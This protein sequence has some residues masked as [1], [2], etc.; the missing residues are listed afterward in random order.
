MT[1]QRISKPPHHLVGAFGG[2]PNGPDRPD[3]AHTSLRSGF[4]TA[5]SKS[6]V[7]RKRRRQ[8]PA[9]PVRLGRLSRPRSMSDLVLVKS[10]GPAIRLS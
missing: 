1:L 5:I 4:S 3:G 10:G 7:E 9:E 2:V 8:G 6:D